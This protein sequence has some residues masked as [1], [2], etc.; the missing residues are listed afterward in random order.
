M[1]R[2]AYK[3]RNAGFEDAGAIFRLIKS[4]PNELLA[5]P[6]SDIVENIDR[7]LVCERDGRVAGTVS[8]QILP[9]IGFS[10]HP[11]VEIKSLAVHRKC[12]AR[13]I[14]SALVEAA[15]KRIK[16]LHPVQIIVLTFVPEF[17]ASLG[18]R[19]TAKEKLMHKLYMG[20][21]NC[22]KYDSPFTCPEVAMS[23]MVRGRPDSDS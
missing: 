4:Y 20:C 22:T 23:M 7:F 5:R 15:I 17:F 3:V 10:K 19:K 13:G 9:E 11:S 2:R 16:S 21:I 6:I 1:K 18:F 8:W 14:G 12:R